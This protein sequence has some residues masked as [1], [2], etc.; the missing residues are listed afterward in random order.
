VSSDWS[1][2]WFVVAPDTRSF[3]LEVSPPGREPWQAV[4]P[5]DSVTRVCFEADGPLASDSLYVFTS[6][7]PESWVIPV[8]AVGGQQL[9]NELIR[10]GLFDASL[11]IEAIQA[12]HGLFCWPPGEPGATR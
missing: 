8:E 10:R 3:S 7:R 5:W 11:A 9:L 1:V 12:H 2:S 6:L 4:I